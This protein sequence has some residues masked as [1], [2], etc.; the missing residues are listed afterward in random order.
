MD[1]TRNKLALFMILLSL[2]A[3]SCGG[4]GGEGGDSGIIASLV[5]DAAYPEA[6]SYLSGVRELPD[7]RLLAADPLSQVLLRVDMDS[8]TADTL[9]TVGGGPEEYQQPDHVFALPGD[10]TLLVDLGKSYLT[11]VGPDGS[12]HGGLPMV[13]N[14]EG[15]SLSL[16]IPEAADGLG[17]I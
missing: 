2:P 10:S 15:G 4:G 5:E 13:A 8:G 14:G 12:F 1:Q 6:F 3:I 17:R 7:G 16:L 11:V 9:G